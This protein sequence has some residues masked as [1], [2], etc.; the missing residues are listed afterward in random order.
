MLAIVNSHTLKGG[1][2]KLPLGHLSAAI[3][4]TLG[5]NLN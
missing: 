2:A 4:Y 3:S 5:V 1:G